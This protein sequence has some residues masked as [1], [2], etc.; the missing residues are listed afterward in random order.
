MKKCTYTSCFRVG[1]TC[2]GCPSGAP[3]RG[4]SKRYVCA[5]LALKGFHSKRS[6]LAKKKVCAFSWIWDHGAGQGHTR[7]MCQT[8]ISKA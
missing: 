5:T 3:P 1:L 7:R 2:I 4:G 8:G 6:R